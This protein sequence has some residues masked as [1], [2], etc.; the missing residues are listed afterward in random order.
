[1][2]LVQ[3]ALIL[4]N[5]LVQLFAMLFLAAPDRRISGFAYQSLY[6]AAYRFNQVVLIYT[7]A[8][9]SAFCYSIVC[10]ASKRIGIGFS[11]ALSAAPMKWLSAMG[12]EDFTLEYVYY[13]IGVSPQCGSRNAALT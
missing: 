6:A 3:F 1:M 8:N 4:G 5:V 7:N 13:F 11:F 12:A 10:K 9:A 2:Y